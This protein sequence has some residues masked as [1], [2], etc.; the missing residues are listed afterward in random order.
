MSCFVFTILYIV[1]IF[2]I[3]A[4]HRKDNIFLDMPY[5]SF[6]F[7]KLTAN[8]FFE[9]I[10][11]RVRLEYGRS[12]IIAPPPKQT[13]SL[14]SLAEDVRMNILL[15]LGTTG[16]S[17]LEKAIRLRRSRQRSDRIDFMRAEKINRRLSKIAS[18]QMNKLIS[19]EEVKEKL[20]LERQIDKG[21]RRD[22]LT[23]LMSLDSD[24]LASILANQN[25]NILGISP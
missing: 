17:Q 23:R 15:F 18:K 24:T 20:A 3:H 5:T 19:L 21:R 2:N 16:M 8:L 22:L 7:R 11:D 6:D 12:S 10:S 13:P 25:M 1:Q 9:W 4:Y 14:A